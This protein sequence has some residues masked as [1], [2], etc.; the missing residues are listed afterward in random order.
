MQLKTSL[1][2]E[3]S[4][5]FLFLVLSS[6]RAIPSDVFRAARSIREVDETGSAC[7]QHL[8]ITA[9]PKKEYFNASVSFVHLFWKICNWAAVSNSTIKCVFFQFLMYVATEAEEG[10]YNLYFHSC[11]NYHDNSE[12]SISFTVSII[13]NQS[14]HFGLQPSMYVRKI[15]SIFV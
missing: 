11:P 9:D 10:L 1:L 3:I 4:P 12:V 5:K 8:P 2:L 14:H 15:T 6:D 13:S 7:S